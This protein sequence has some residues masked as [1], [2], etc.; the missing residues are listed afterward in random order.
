KAYDMKNQIDNETKH[1]RSEILIKLAEKNKKEFEENLIGKE[2]DVLFEQKDGD[3]FE[4]H[5]KNYVKVYV[6]T[7]KDLSGK[8]I[9]VKIKEI[10]NNKV[11]GE[12]LI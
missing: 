9:D 3:F 5:T 11:I 6:E 2:F 1:K 8:L 4:G 12:L 7:N 10:K